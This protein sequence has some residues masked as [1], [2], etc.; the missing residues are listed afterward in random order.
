MKYR[1]KRL[2]YYWRFE[3]I[4]PA[5]HQMAELPLSGIP[6]DMKKLDV[7]IRWAPG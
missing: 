5:N 6:S 2:K 4:A 1:L 7:L 3:D